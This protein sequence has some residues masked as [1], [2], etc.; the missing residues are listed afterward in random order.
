MLRV[1]SAVF[2]PRW[3]RFSS[4]GQRGPDVVARFLRRSPGGT[5]MELN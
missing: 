4:R 5:R 1:V 2:Y 3:S